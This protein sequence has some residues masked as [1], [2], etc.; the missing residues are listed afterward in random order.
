MDD[1]KNPD[2]HEQEMQ[3]LTKW[4]DFFS[5]RF[6]MNIDWGKEKT[7]IDKQEMMVTEYL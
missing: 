2:V 6:F 4:E 5:S 7:G 3:T 1:K